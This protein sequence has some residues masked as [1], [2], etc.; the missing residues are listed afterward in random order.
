LIADFLLESDLAG[1]AGLGGMMDMVEQNTRRRIMAVPY[2]LS[3]SMGF[4]SKRR[5]TGLR[6]RARL[7]EGIVRRVASDQRKSLWGADFSRSIRYANFGSSE[8]CKRRS[9]GQ[10]TMPEC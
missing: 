3:Q 4:P 5:R 7:Q 8:S 10:R 6:W 9:I 2:T 1:M